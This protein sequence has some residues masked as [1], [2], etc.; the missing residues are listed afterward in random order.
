MS[1]T[2]GAI[3]PAVAER[4]IA[5]IGQCVEPLPTTA[6][7]VSRR[8]RTGATGVSQ[9]FRCRPLRPK[10]RTL[11]P[12]VYR[13]GPREYNGAA[14]AGIAEHQSTGRRSTGRA[15]GARAAERKTC[16]RRMAQSSTQLH[17]EPGER[18]GP[19]RLPLHVV[20]AAEVRPFSRHRPLRVDVAA[21]LRRRDV[22][23]GAL[24]SERIL[25]RWSE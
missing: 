20:D 9:C 25:R 13:R 10:L 24:S 21:G 3:A 1:T 11:S 15:S 8:W 5:H 22:F 19:A 23:A 14:T 16:L 17:V 4:A 18:R 2:P 12:R 7:G 6:C